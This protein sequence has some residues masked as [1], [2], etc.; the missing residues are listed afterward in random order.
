MF[1]YRMYKVQNHMRYL[2]KLKINNLRLKYVYVY[3]IYIFFNLKR[4]FY[5]KI[6]NFTLKKNSYKLNK[7]GKFEIC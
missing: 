1:S 5:I 7:K 3:C 4:L 2:K 6:L